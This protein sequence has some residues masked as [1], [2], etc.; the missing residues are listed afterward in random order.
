M[1]YTLAFDVYGTLIDTSGV[2]Q[3]L[4][5]MI[6]EY[7]T[8]FMQT[9]RGK[10]L[11]YSFRRG[12]MNKHV[13]F[14]IVTLQ[15]LDYTCLFYSISLPKSQR[16]ALMEEYKVLPAFSDVNEALNDLK[17]TDYRLFAF[18]NGSYKAVEGLLK[19]AKIIDLFDGIVSC[20]AV[21]MFKPN[22]MVYQHFN[23]TTNSEPTKTWLISG[24]PFDVL[25]AISYGMKG[26]WV[27]RKS[28]SIFDPWG[29]DPTITIQ[30]LKELTFSLK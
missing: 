26:A 19:Q 4:Q 8:P 23:N 1:S 12:L 21:N 18:S 10:Q 17:K 16:A 6:G 27:R 24:N 25:G 11:E 9:W 2:Y 14:S 29:I 30:S 22:P 15:A 20:E 13:D 5:Q 7:A 3:S 28:D